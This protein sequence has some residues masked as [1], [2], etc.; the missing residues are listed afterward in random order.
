[1]QDCNRP[2]TASPA[3]PIPKP[4]P[5]RCARPGAA[6][7]FDS[8]MSPAHPSTAA[9]ARTMDLHTIP[10]QTH[11]G[12]PFSTIL[13]QHNRPMVAACHRHLAGCCQRPPQR[14]LLRRKWRVDGPV[15]SA[16]SA[17]PGIFDRLGIRRAPC[18]AW[19]PK[20][21]SVRAT[22]ETFGY[23]RAAGQRGCCKQRVPPWLHPQ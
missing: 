19:S 12:L 4:H 13:K 16:C 22:D 18:G 5:L 9:Y 20:M 17:R 15:C 3:P 1:M 11:H 2:S 8:G 14:A 6:R 23:F 10:G 7:P 21:N